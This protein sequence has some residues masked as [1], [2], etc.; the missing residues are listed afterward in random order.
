MTE[1]SANSS[2]AIRD[3]CNPAP[4][5]TCSITPSRFRKPPSLRPYHATLVVA[6]ICAFFSF[7]PIASAGPLNGEF[8]INATAGKM[9]APAV[10][11]AP[12]G[13]F[14]VVWEG[15]VT[16]DDIWARQFDAT[17]TAVG[18]DFQINSS[19]GKHKNPAISMASDGSFVVVW[20]SNGSSGSD[21]DSTSIQGQRYA[22]PPSE[23]PTV[24][25]ALSPS[26]LIALVALLMGAGALLLR[27]RLR[28]AN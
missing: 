26:G 16:V 25:P 4:L 6:L 13:S 23:P 15:K 8:Q 1:H 22:G 10:A 17:G 11:A 2:R 9:K 3:Q 5:H 18:G 21:T 20:E 7:R 27:G 12:D 14:T 24:V 28:L 19:A